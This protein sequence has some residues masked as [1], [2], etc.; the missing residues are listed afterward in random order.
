MPRLIRVFLLLGF[1]SPCASLGQETARF[2]PSDVFA[3]DQLFD[4]YNQAFS[5]KDYV[6]LRDYLQAPFLGFGNVFG[7][8]GLNLHTMDAVMN[9]YRALRDGLDAQ[10]YER[11]QLIQ[12]RITALSSD[13]ALVNGTYRRYRKD[14]SI[15]LEAAGIYLVTKSSG[16]WKICGFSAQE[17]GE[18][19]KVY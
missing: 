9:S 7:M 5:S 15:L 19:G 4:R 8:D 14:G 3:I 18:F 12:R 13:R 16:T 2:G 17:I 6:K 11:S 10:Q 1:L